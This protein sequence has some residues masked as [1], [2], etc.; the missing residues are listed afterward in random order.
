MHYYSNAEVLGYGRWTI[1]AVF[2]SLIL[3]CND[4]IIDVSQINRSQ[5]IGEWM[6]EN[7]S[8]ERTLDSND[9][10][11]EVNSHFTIILNEDGTGF[12]ENSI[13][14]E[15]LEWVYQYSPE[16]VV[17]SETQTILGGI[18]QLRS[19]TFFDI[20]QNDNTNQ[21]WAATYSSV[22]GSIMTIVQLEWAL[23]K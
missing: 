16:M 17:I 9:L 3:S 5:L 4:E 2:I 13:V 15:P 19:T 11:N 10:V 8:E 12:I 22:E 6:V 18:G 1:W 20:I 21:K 14:L 7:H 23:T